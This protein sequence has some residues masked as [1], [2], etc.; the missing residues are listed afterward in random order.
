MIN[1]IK[2]FCGCDKKENEGFVTAHSRT[3]PS[4]KLRKVPEELSYYEKSRLRLEEFSPRDLDS[5]NTSYMSIDVFDT[6][7]S[8]IIKEKTPEE[9]ETKKCFQTIYKNTQE[10]K[11]IQY[12]TQDLSVSETTAK[13]FSES[14]N[15][16]A[17]SVLAHSF[18]TNE[19]QGINIDA[20]TALLPSEENNMQVVNHIHST[21][22]IPSVEQ[23]IENLKQTMKDK[24]KPVENAFKKL[25][26]GRGV[27]EREVEKFCNLIAKVAEESITGIVDKKIGTYKGTITKTINFIINS[28]NTYN[29]AKKVSNLVIDLLVTISL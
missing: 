24:L 12:L 16:V 29:C 27:D 26:L 10:K 25:L 15:E 6:A 20:L 13:K 17:S 18:S 2:R 4:N 7:R 28:Y 5:C 1:L 23:N 22:V 21:D 9:V 11:I 14:L 3:L 19:T 8:R